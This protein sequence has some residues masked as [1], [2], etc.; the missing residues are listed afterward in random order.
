[1]KWSWRVGTFAGIGVYVHATFPLLLAWIALVQRRGGASTAGV[2][3]AVG[4]VLAVFVV[5]VMHEFGHALTARR[6][7]IATRDI[8]LLPIGGVARL[9]RMPREPRQELAIALAGPA[10]NVAVAILLYVVLRVTGGP[11][12]LPDF[13]ANG[14][15]ISPRLAMLQ[16][17]GINVWL[18]VFNMI[19]AFPLDGGRVLRAI[20]AMGKRDYAAAT[21]AAA[22]IGRGFAVLF[23]LA[24]L[25]VIGNPMLV[26]IAAFVWLAATAEASSVRTSA[27]L[28]GVT[29]ADLMITDLHVLAPHDPLARA[30]QL[31]I[32][33]FQQDFPVVDRGRL[34][35][36]LSR[37]DLVQ[38]L[39]A[40][41]PTMAVLEVMRTDA[42]TVAVT[43]PVDEALARLSTARRG[44]LPI[45]RG[46][47]LVG[48][49]TAEN[50]MEYLMLRKAVDPDALG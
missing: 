15:T 43:D 25:F 18:A 7:G 36:M 37:A 29:L 11:I 9:E 27:A 24:G 34:V 12:E 44:A 13:A 40:H 19:P 48:L 28:E 4:L 5:V 2:L 3:Y 42:P 46:Q 39:T 17:L 8:T 31:L 47:S 32:D 10:V 22:R 20:L 38:G 50:V 23:G 30:A 14:T 35:G 49:L 6:Y 1:M 21:V 16:L 45:L 33:G 26:L 41:G